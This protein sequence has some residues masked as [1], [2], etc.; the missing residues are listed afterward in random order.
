MFLIKECIQYFYLCEGVC[1][2]DINISRDKNIR[3]SFMRQFKC[4]ICITHLSNPSTYLS[5]SGTSP[6]PMNSSFPA[7][8][9]QHAVRISFSFSHPVSLS[10]VSMYVDLCFPLFYIPRFGFHRWTFQ[11][12]DLSFGA[13]FNRWTLQSANLSASGNFSH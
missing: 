10:S 13:P 4:V 6:D 11:P 1:H 2:N 8:S 3:F 9:I 7:I 5:R 12:V